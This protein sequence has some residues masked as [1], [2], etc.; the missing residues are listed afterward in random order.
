M[1]FTDAQLKFLNKEFGLNDTAISQMDDAYLG[2]LYENI[3][4]IEIAETLLADDEALSERGEIAVTLVNDIAEIL[5][6]VRDD[7]KEQEYEQ[8]DEPA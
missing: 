3:C 4:D 2:D 5:G 8:K 7:D 6:Y 1:E